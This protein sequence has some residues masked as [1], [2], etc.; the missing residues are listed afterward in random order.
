MQWTFADTGTATAGSA[1]ARLGRE[2]DRDGA[3]TSLEILKQ[4]I[5]TFDSD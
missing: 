3:D 2:L 1:Q 5:Y 4:I